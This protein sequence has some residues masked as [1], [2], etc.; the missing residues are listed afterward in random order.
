MIE[1]SGIPIEDVETEYGHIFSYEFS[2]F[3][4]VES[5]IVIIVSPPI[6]NVT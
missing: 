1:D 3:A 6:I 2:K 5:T 4:V